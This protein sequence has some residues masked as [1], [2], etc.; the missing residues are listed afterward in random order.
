MALFWNLPLLPCAYLKSWMWRKQQKERCGI[1]YIRYAKVGAVVVGG[2]QSG[3]QMHSNGE[4][5]K[6][7]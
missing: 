3:L 6:A 5:A 2:L 7:T 4:K 1:R